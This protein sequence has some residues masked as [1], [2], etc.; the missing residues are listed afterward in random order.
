MAA[1]GIKNRQ[2]GQGEG[3]S[4]WVTVLSHQEDGK[5]QLSG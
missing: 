2:Q 1:V 3:S 4:E 5:K